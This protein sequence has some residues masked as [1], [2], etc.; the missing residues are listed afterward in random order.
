MA[1][2]SKKLDRQNAMQSLGHQL[3]KYYT[4]LANANDSRKLHP[5]YLK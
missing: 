4:Q 1:K 3:E 2:K 5:Y